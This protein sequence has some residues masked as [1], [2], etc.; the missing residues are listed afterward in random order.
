MG[1][2]PVPAM[3][4]KS[5]RPPSAKPLKLP[6]LKKRL[7]LVRASR[8]FA[9]LGGIMKVFANAFGVAILFAA[10]AGH[11]QTTTDGGVAPMQVTKA[12][13]A[14]S[15]YLPANTEV[16]VSMNQELTTKGK[17]WNE[18]D[19]FNMTVVHDVMYGDYVIIPKGSRAVG[20]ISWLTNKG[21][22]GKSGKMEIEIEYAQVGGR[23][24]PLTGQYR[25]EGEGNTVATIGGVVAAGVFAAFITGKSGRIPAGR[26]LMAY[27]KEDL[28]LAFDGPPPQQNAAFTVRQPAP[29]GV[30]APAPVE[31]PAEAAIIEPVA[32]EATK[33]V[34]VPVTAN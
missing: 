4:A 3:G 28:P 26:E 9:D 12:G 2:V 25:Q 6:T 13:P 1:K 17:T 11:A 31:A 8:D 32:E 5:L 21:A 18:G 15:A 19:T 7:H 10:T 29:M 27:T 16:L 30:A 22:F 24:I 34:L 23:R 14:A 33:P 20:R